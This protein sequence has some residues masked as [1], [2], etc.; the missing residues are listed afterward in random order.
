MVHENQH[1]A[2]EDTGDKLLRWPWIDHNP[3]ISYI[4][5]HRAAALSNIN[6]LYFIC[7]SQISS[8]AALRNAEQ[9]SPEATEVRMSR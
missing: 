8:D 2:M 1:L 7:K 5:G 3:N 4:E 6:T 9:D